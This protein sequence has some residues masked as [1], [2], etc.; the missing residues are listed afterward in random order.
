M[1]DA[2]NKATQAENWTL[3]CRKHKLSEKKLVV[4]GMLQ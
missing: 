1:T 4:N 3:T 2:L